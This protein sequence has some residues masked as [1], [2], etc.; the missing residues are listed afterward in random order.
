[1]LNKRAKSLVAVGGAEKKRLA[2]EGRKLVAAVVRLRGRLQQ[3]AFEL[4]RALR[5]LKEKAMLAALGFPSFRALCETAL[6]ISNDLADQL[7]A[8]AESFSAKQARKLGTAKAIAVIDLAK[9]MPGAHTPAGLLA[10][11]AVKI[12]RRTVDVRD[13]SAHDITAAARAIR[14]ARPARAT[15]GVSVAPSERHLAAALAHA[16]AGRHVEAKVTAVAAGKATGARVRLE[17]PMRDLAALATCIHE[18][19]A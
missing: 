5:P 8:I 1:M 15:G 12:G 4:G 7:I 6:G 3:T 17:L 2:R 10:K 11:R 16:L 14:Q 13:A 9:T 18:V 19:R